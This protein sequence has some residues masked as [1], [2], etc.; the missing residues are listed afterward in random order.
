MTFVYYQRTENI[1][2]WYNFPNL[3]NKKGQNQI[4]ASL[5]L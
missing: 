3:G 4:L 5:L 2:E 1:H